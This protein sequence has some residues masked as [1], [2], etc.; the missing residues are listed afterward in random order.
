MQ[1]QI[2]LYQPVSTATDKPF[3]AMTLLIL[4]GMSC[5]FMMAFYGMLYWKKNTLQVEMTALKGQFEQ[6]TKTVEKLEATVARVTDSKNEQQQLKHLKTVFANKQN[7]LNELSTMVRGNDSGLS[8]FFSALARKNI[9]AVW[10]DHIDVYSGGQQVILQ[11]QTLDAKYIPG[12]VLSLKEEPVFNGVSFRLFNVQRNDMDNA[13][14]F[15]LQTETAEN[16]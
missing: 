11:G 16:L 1:Q 13:L 15:V 7:A 8:D 12:F 14:H 4:I 2:N 3:S 9:E 10:F 6:T 5:F